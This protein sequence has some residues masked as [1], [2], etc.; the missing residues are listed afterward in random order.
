MTHLT[1]QVIEVA[2][3]KT[4]NGLHVDVILLFISEIAL[5]FK[6]SKRDVPDEM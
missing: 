6:S 2:S 3:S 4:N 1:C 5:T